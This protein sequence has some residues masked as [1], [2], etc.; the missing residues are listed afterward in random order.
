MLSLRGDLWAVSMLV[1]LLSDAEGGCEL[2]LVFIVS[3]GQYMEP[4]DIS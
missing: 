3:S 2:N 1:V 4:L